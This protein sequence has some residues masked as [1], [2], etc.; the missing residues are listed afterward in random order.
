VGVKKTAPNIGRLATS[1][2]EDKKK[3]RKPM[4]NTIDIFKDSDVG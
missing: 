4:K 2:T 1:R 3:K